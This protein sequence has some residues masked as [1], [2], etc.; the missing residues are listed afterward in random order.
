MLFAGLI[1][2]LDSGLVDEHA[3]V[4]LH[5]DGVAVVPLNAAFDLLAVFEDNDHP[6]LRLDLLLEVKGFGVGALV[7]CGVTN[8]VLVSQN[9]G[10]LMQV[11]DAVV[12]ILLGKPGTDKLARAGNG[13]GGA[14]I[15][16]IHS[17]Y[18]WNGLE[19]DPVLL[20]GRLGME[21]RQSCYRAL[22]SIR[23]DF[24]S[25][26][27]RIDATLWPGRCFYFYFVRSVVWHL[28]TD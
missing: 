7:V 2:V 22:R 25:I 17:F 4:A 19:P 3:G 5:L 18:R 24:H 11:E 26:A 23:H 14:F 21:S 1:D 13:K 15:R 9:R 20:H 12:G 8:H 28:S 10:F 6:G 27:E 16:R